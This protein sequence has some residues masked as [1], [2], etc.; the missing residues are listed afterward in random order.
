[1][2][3]GYFEQSR[4][5]LVGLIDHSDEAPRLSGALGDSAFL[6]AEDV[7]KIGPP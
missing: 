7:C 6:F 4:H 2:E 3:M 1:M 5:S